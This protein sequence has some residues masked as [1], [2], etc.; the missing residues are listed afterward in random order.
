MT[1]WSSERG[2]Q[3]WRRPLENRHV[4][5]MKA[6]AVTIAIWVLMAVDT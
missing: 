4:E 2:P 6:A 5:R 3:G 1:I